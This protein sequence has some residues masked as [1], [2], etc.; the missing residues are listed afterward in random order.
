MDKIFPVII[1]LLAVVILIAFFLPWLSIGSQRLDVF[2]KILTGKEGQTMDKVSA[3]QIPILA[4][5]EEAKLMITIIQIFNPGIEN[6]DK[7]SFLVWGIVVLA[8][9]I[10]ALSFFLGKNHWFNLVIAILGIA[11]FVVTIVKINTTNLDKLILLVKV[12]EGLWLTIYSYLAIGLLSLMRS[13]QLIRRK[14]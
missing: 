11:I 5:S 2:T 12:R 10:A 1:T 13:I 8:G 4:N 6:A 3:F 7:K 9:I 14:A